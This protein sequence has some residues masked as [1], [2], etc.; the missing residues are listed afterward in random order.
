VAARLYYPPSP[1]LTT[2]DRP[3]SLFLSGLDAKK[4]FSTSVPEDSALMET[5]PLFSSG[6]SQP[7]KVADAPTVDSGEAT[8][9]RKGAGSD[10]EKGVQE[11]LE[12]LCV[13]GAAH[14][15]LCQVRACE[16]LKLCLII[17]CPQAVCSI[18][19]A[20]HCESF[21]NCRRNSFTLVG[22]FIRLDA[23]IL[24]WPII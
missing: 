8:V 12:L 3:R 11:I 10:E 4:S 13:L 6:K 9:V 15:R 17:V 23:P 5:P 16:W 20:K 1:E 21:I 7:E 14:K 22:Y 19:V 24:K 2:P 18:N